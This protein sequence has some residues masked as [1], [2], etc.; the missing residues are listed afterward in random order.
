MS[1]E[2]FAAR[3]YEDA[4]IV[5]R[6]ATRSRLLPAEAKLLETYRAEI[7]DRR[8]LDLGCGA[9]RTTAHLRALTRNYVGIDYSLAMIESCRRRHPAA[10]FIHGDAT[11][12]SMVDTNSIDVALFSY[13]GIDTMSHDRRLRVLRE[14]HRVLVPEGLFAFSS[15]N[16][17]NC[18]VVVA[19]DRS[20]GLG[21]QA[22]LRNTTNLLSYLLI[23]SKQVKTDT[24]WI[25][26][27]PRI[28]FRQLSYSINKMN[29]IEQLKQNGFT[30][31]A[32]LNEE[33]ELVPAA[34]VDRETRWFYYTCRKRRASG[35]A[36][37]A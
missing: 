31:V 4:N 19:I 12:L 17:D 26:S 13:N 20:L 33:S 2:Q 25:R 5:R 30:V 27:D 15:H 32:I 7:A 6:H 29:Q 23:R 16:L 9:G 22:L 10:N 18:R 11:D 35:S 34:T 3:H 8:V 14:V 28:G 1:I 37:D 24:Y 21:P 36:A